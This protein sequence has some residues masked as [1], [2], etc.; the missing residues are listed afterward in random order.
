MTSPTKVSD[1]GDRCRG[2]I[3][4]RAGWQRARPI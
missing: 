2:R 4:I 1:I 3:K